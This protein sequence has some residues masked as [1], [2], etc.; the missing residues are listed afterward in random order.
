M[1]LSSLTLE[2]IWQLSLREREQMAVCAQYRGTAPCVQSGKHRSRL[3]TTAA[4]KL[5][6]E[7]AAAQ[8]RQVRKPPRLPCPL[9]AALSENVSSSIF[10]TLGMLIQHKFTCSDV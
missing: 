8:D 5:S 10:I 7:R 4:I 3:S 6:P 9:P 1:N 2:G